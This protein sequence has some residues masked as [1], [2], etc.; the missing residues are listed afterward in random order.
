MFGFEV[1]KIILLYGKY[2]YYLADFNKTPSSSGK[3]NIQSY[4]LVK[5]DLLIKFGYISRLRRSVFIT[6]WL[7]RI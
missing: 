4:D 2:D 3:A 6:N 5:L 1:N 7:L